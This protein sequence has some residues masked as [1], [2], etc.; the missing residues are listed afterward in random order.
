MCITVIRIDHKKCGPNA[1]VYPPDCGKCLKACDPAVLVMHQP[2]YKESDVN[3]PEGWRISPVW[4]PLCTRCKKC[5]DVCPEN[6]ISV[7]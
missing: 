7:W 6:A 3:D 2:F 5:V 1:T 4:I